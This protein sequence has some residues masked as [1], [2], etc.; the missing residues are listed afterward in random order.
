MSRALIA[1]MERQPRPEGSRAGPADRLRYPHDRRTLETEVSPGAVRRTR[2]APGPGDRPGADGR[3]ALHLMP[4]VSPE[5]VH[6]ITKILLRIGVDV[7]GK[8]SMGR[9]PLHLA[10][11]AQALELC[12]LLIKGKGDINIQDKAGMSPLDVSLDKKS[13]QVV[14]SKK[15]MQALLRKHGGKTGVHLR[16]EPILK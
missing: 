14:N 6:K 7:N 13:H 9:T 15:E 3:N 12:K 16:I 11:E 10:V 8:D 1:A 5:N 2:R 4:R